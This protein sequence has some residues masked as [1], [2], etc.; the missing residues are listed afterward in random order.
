MPQDLKDWRVDWIGDYAILQRLR[1]SPEASTHS[2]PTSIIDY[3][4]GLNAV[5]FAKA[6]MA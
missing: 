6:E 1:A 5:L 4:L 3:Y 2:N